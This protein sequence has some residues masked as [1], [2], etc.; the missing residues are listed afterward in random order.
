MATIQFSYPSMTGTQAKPTDAFTCN[1][2]SGYFTY[3]NTSNGTPSYHTFVP[4]EIYASASNLVI[5]HT[6]SINSLNNIYVIFSL[7]NDSTANPLIKDKSINLNSLILDQLDRK[8]DFSLISDISYATTETLNTFTNG[9]HYFNIPGKI[10]TKYT[11][12]N[13]TEATTIVSNYTTATATSNKTLNIKMTPASFAHEEIICDDATIDKS[14]NIDNYAGKVAGNIGL[15]IGVGISV[16][17]VLLLVLTKFF[18]A[19]DFPVDTSLFGWG[20]TDNNNY[21]GYVG[22]ML[23]FWVLS[24]ACFFGY[25]G[26][27][28][29]SSGPT[30]AKDS[31]VSSLLSSAIIFLIMFIIMVWY[32]VKYLTL[33]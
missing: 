18:T 28:L 15:N 11:N 32:K 29:G 22:L 12:F 23:V 8:L 14:T 6:N 16:I 27:M 30:K 31:V 25:G 33:P 7:S 19:R 5:K 17:V 9:N 26:R 24:L 1:P 10:N 21:K 4:T 3:T 13:A 2:N 20:T